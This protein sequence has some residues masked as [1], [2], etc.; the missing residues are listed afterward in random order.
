MIVRTQD[1][2]ETFP[3]NCHMALTVQVAARSREP[4]ARVILDM[5]QV[6]VMF[7]SQWALEGFT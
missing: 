4:W 6:K 5:L 1:S 2:V 3:I 7:M